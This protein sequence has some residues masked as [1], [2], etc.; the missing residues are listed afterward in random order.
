M[1]TSFGRVSNLNLITLGR[2]RNL[3]TLSRLS[4]LITLGHVSGLMAF[5]RV[6]GLMNVARPFKAGKPSS[7]MSGVASA[8]LDPCLHSTLS[9]QNGGPTFWPLKNTGS[10]QQAARLISNNPCRYGMLSL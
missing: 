1:L 6:C 2:D 8:T 5:V 7:A 4:N 3:I 9:K 10:T